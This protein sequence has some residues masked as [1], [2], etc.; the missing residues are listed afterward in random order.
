MPGGCQR[1]ILGFDEALGLG[2]VETSPKYLGLISGF[3]DIGST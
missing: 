3:H 2:F 1:E